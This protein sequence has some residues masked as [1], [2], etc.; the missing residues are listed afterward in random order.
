MEIITYG[1]LNK[2]RPGSVQSNL[3][4]KLDITEGDSETNNWREFSRINR[5]DL[6]VD[7]GEEETYLVRF[8][9]G[10]SIWFKLFLNG[11]GEQN[12]HIELHDRSRGNIYC[13]RAGSR[14]WYGGERTDFRI[15]RSWECEDE[16]NMILE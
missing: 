8:P 3:Q 10:D 9:C 6:A 11:D 16:E 15:E 13:N 1:S 7:M 2:L 4:C 14:S 5:L 12:S